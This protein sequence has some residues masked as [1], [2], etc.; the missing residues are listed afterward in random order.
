MR[1]IALDHAATAEL[2]TEVLRK[3]QSLRLKCHGGSM[4]PFLRNGAIVTTEPVQPHQLAVG[5][6]VLYRR[7]AGI[8]VHRVV[9]KSTQCGKEELLIRGDAVVG[10]DEWVPHD[11]VLGRVVRV[12]HGDR[13]MRLDRGFWTWMGILWARLS[14]LAR[15]M[16]RWI[17]ALLKVIRMPALR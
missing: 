6:V 5:Q 10:S 12:E 7:G 3:G 2:V 13:M 15:P 14:P 17:A 8:A 16:V 9:A 11:L 1:E 4:A